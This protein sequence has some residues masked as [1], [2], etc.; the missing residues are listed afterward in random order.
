EDSSVALAQIIDKHYSHT[1]RG[2]KEVI[3]L[4]INYDEKDKNYT[5]K[6][7]ILKL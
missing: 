7:E 6:L 4:G 2:Y 5:A 1:L 3:A